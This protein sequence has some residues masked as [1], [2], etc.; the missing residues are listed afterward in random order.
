[1]GFFCTRIIGT[2]AYLPTE[3]M[4]NN[5]FESYA[6]Y[7]SDHSR[8]NKPSNEIVNKLTEISGI[9][10]RRYATA[11]LHTSDIAFFA[12]KDAIE[13]SGIDPETLDYDIV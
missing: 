5:F 4:S 12:G 11:N 2:G 1:M 8:N 13:S 3:V 6:F 7:N 9:T 10:E